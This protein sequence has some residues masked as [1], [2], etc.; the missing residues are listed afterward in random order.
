MSKRKTTEPLPT[1]KIPKLEKVENEGNFF[2]F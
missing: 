2:M 1:N